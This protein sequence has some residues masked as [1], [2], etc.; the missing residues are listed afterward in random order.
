M[1]TPILAIESLL[2][3]EG[4]LPINVKVL[5]EGQEEIGSP[6]LPDIVRGHKDLLACDLV[7][8]ADGWQWAEDQPSLLHGLRV[9]VQCK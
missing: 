3:S 4:K 7:I 1:L 8:S 9:Y 2:K 6:E 5:F